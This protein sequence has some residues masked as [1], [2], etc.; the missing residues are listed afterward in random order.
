MVNISNWWAFSPFEN[1][2][3]SL[4]RS[5]EFPSCQQPSDIIVCTSLE[6][7]STKKPNKF[8]E[9]LNIP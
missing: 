6:N 2:P 3:G 9:S 8:L 1:M 7:L 4:I 5:I